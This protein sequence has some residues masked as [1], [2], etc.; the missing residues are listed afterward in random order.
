MGMIRPCPRFSSHPDCPKPPAGYGVDNTFYAAGS[1]ITGGQPS[2]EITGLQMVVANYGLH[3]PG[4]SEFFYNGEAKVDLY[5]KA[6][7]VT[8]G[9]VVGAAGPGC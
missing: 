3:T 1:A 2:G 8:M 7:L 5:E 4:V 9:P 6:P